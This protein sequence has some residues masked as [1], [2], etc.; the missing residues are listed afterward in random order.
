MA[1]AHETRLQF[2]PAAV[3]VLVM[4]VDEGIRS[5]L[6]DLLQ[7]VGYA[8]V[9]LGDIHE[10]KTLVNTA[11]EPLVLV[12]GNAQVPDYTGLEFFTEAAASSARRRHAYIYL[13]TDTYLTTV[14]GSSRQKELDQVLTS[15]GAQRLPKPFDLPSLLA[16]VDAAST[17][18]Y[19]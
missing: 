10:A 15:L 8:V 1:I 5:V 12:I 16:G 3:T 11:T 14:P 18:L 13:T 9:T 7:E 19:A 2:T 17:R 4:D 6:G